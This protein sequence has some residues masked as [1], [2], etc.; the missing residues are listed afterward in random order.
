MIESNPP[1][2]NDLPLH[3]KNLQN[4]LEN[5]E[6]TSIPDELRLN[7]LST[8]SKK[9]ENDEVILEDT[10]E[11]H[12]EMKQTALFMKSSNLIDNGDEAP[13]SKNSPPKYTIF[14]PDLNKKKSLYLKN[15]K[16]V[17]AP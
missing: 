7:E 4:A 15:I 10:V 16:N 5:P 17:D 2:N 12:D 1:P 3:L 8:D 11:I 14:S 13:N 6:T 9:S